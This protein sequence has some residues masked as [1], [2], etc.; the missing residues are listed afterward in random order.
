MKGAKGAK[1]VK[2]M[3]GMMGVKGDQGKARR[4]SVRDDG[5]LEGCSTRERGS[6]RG[7]SDEG[8][9]EGERKAGRGDGSDL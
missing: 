9:E 8:G 6:V 7:W 5:C 4:G 1:E 2:G 3:K